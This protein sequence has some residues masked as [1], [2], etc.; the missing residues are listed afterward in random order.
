MT[1]DMKVVIAIVK[2][3]PGEQVTSD[4]AAALQYLAAQPYADMARLGVTGFCWGGGATWNCCEHSRSS[5]PGWPGTV[6]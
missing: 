6:D 1:E 3:T 5:K 4:T 2:A